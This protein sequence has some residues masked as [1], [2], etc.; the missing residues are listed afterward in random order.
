MKHTIRQTAKWITLLALLGLLIGCQAHQP[1]AEIS[2]DEIG[3][4]V[5]EVGDSDNDAELVVEVE[6]PAVEQVS[7][8]D[9]VAGAD[10]IFLGRVDYISETMTRADGSPYYQ[11]AVSVL[12]PLVDEVNLGT[13]GVLIV[14]GHSPL[15]SKDE[16]AASLQVDA[17]MVLFVRQDGT[18]LVPFVDNGSAFMDAGQFNTLIFEILQQ[19]PNQLL[20]QAD[21]NGV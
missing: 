1:A 5:S 6:I 12:Q 7:R 13:G 20:P 8:T 10:A 3:N 17:E 19:R 18:V 21:N 9:M 14:S 16:T 2:S 4:T 11:I 15:E